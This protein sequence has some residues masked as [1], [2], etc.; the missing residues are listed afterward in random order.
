MKRRFIYAS[1]LL[2]ITNTVLFAQGRI[3]L[4]GK[5]KCS[6]G[7]ITLPGTVDQS[8]LA[9]SNTDNTTT[10]NLTR[11]NPY[12]GIMEYSTTVSIP[13]S[14]EGKKIM[15]YL[16]RTRPTTLYIDGDSIGC[17]QY[18]ETPHIYDLTGK[19]SFGIHTIKIKVDNRN[20]AVPKEVHGSHM[21][22][23][24][25]QTNWNG[26]LGD[27]YIEAK[28]DIYVDQM[29]V[30]PAAGLNGVIFECTICADK[31]YK[32]ATIGF[33]GQ[34]ELGLKQK[35][36][37]T[38][39]T[40]YNWSKLDDNTINDLMIT[41]DGSCK[42]SSDN[43]SEVEIEYTKIKPNG[44]TDNAK[45]GTKLLKTVRLETALKKGMNKIRFTIKS[46]SL[47]L[48]SEFHPYIHCWNIKVSTKD[49][50][51]VEISHPFSFGLRQ[52]E[53]SGNTFMI[54]KIPVFLRG[55]H[56]GC[57]WPITAYAPM[58]TDDWGYY[59]AT[60]KM[61]GFNHLRCHSW[62]VPE[63]AFE[64][65]DRLG[66]YIQVELPYW[67]EFKADNEFCNNFMMQE[68]LAILKTYG[69][70]PSFFSL[71]LGNELHGDLRTMQ[72]FCRTFRETDSRHLYV[73]GANNNLGWKGQMAGDDYF[74]TCR[75]GGGTNYSSN[76]RSSFS[77][78]DENDGGLLNTMRPNTLYNYANAIRNITIPVVSH[79]TGQFQSFPNFSETEKYNGVLAPVNFEIFRKRMAEH[80][81][82]NKDDEYSFSSS[83]WAFNCYKA[84]IEMC[85]RTPNFGGFQMLDLQDYP[86]QGTALVGL[87]DAF[88]ER[89]NNRITPAMFR[90][91]NSPLTIMG[92]HPSFCYMADDRVYANI[93]IANFTE[94]D[95]S[96]RVRWKIMKE[97]MTELGSGS[98]S[99][100]APRGMVTK[101]VSPEL[102]DIVP[103][104]RG[105]NIDKESSG[106]SVIFPENIPTGMYFLE[107]RFGNAT[108]HYMFYVYNK[109]S[110]NNEFVNKIEKAT[111]GFDWDAQTHIAYTQEDAIAA[112]N[113]GKDVL[114]IP[115]HKDI[116]PFSLKGLFTP[117]YWNYSMFKGICEGLKKEVSPGTL[118]INTRRQH[119]IFNHFP[120]DNYTNWQWWSILH[121]SRPMILDNTDENFRPVIEM[122]DNVERCHKLGI[123][124]EAKLGKG[125]I[126]IC[127]TNLQK[128]TSY[129]EGKAYISSIL[130][131]LTSDDF[132]PKYQLSLQQFNDLFHK[133][134][135]EVNLKGVKNISNY[136]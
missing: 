72:D 107:L 95:V 37:T 61:Y 74:I 54:N 46:N 123:M 82:T 67:G 134:V 30:Y 100:T 63:A 6:L 62:T 77:F 57:V 10:G 130:H 51:E 119:P 52:F 31:D 114:Y 64:A 106:A 53:I 21:W 42:V 8:R 117:D 85:M 17:Q 38:S 122:I 25:T 39:S 50:N 32:K 22:S 120:T 131:Y 98:F 103:T 7:T 70:H 27:M 24:S 29:Q 11:R 84:D 45:S 115:S 104:N 116:E 136:K 41:P 83:F 12:V 112:A 65:A 105:C 75:N 59:L 36:V 15:L 118:S 108:N 68:G 35:C 101:S 126:L 129:P 16:E 43:D 58:N 132:V 121:N 9:Q 127:T 4:S 135:A 60:L 124:M 94:N 66:I 55:K 78:A 49:K 40:N 90:E 80:G 19:I 79:E 92:E 97:D 99:L 96:D 14:F 71:S 26:I 76:T 102:I 73:L 111:A 81:L 23:E 113:K 20:E 56:D 87:L 88:M 13:Q 93:V 28:P 33:D 48:W 3:D 89:K 110:I 86:G 91:F 47:K 128:I 1:V 133:K 44:Q 125:N 109:Q 69:N 18:L 5:W 34:T 2:L